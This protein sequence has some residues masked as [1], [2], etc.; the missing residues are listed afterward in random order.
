MFKVNV[1]WDGVNHY[2]S[3]GNYDYALK[4]L[5]HFDRVARA[6]KADGLINDYYVELIRED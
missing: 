4:A 3:Y 2:E 6:Y 1:C 5:K